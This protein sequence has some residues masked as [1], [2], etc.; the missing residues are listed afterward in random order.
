MLGYK[1]YFISRA[2]D[3][4]NSLIKKLHGKGKTNDWT[5]KVTSFPHCV[6]FS[7]P[8]LSTCMQSSRLLSMSKRQASPLSCNVEA[9][10]ACDCPNLF[11]N[12][13]WGTRIA[14]SLP[15][16]YEVWEL[17]SINALEN[18]ITKE[19]GKRE[20]SNRNNSPVTSKACT[21]LDASLHFTFF[22]FSFFFLAF[23]HFLFDPQY[24]QHDIGQQLHVLLGG[25]VA[26]GAS[27]PYK[28]CLLKT[29]PVPTYI[30]PWIPSRPFM[31]I[32]TEKLRE[33]CSEYQLIYLLIKL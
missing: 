17:V 13:S 18:I 25:F 4:C 3:N 24:K 15:I 14:F 27:Y 21:F 16:S 5:G 10:N 22:C 31:L 1:F 19:K 32:C 7:Y 20:K 30:G 23:K 26:V 2:Q 29:Q 8:Q 6:L 33:T 9:K 12:F 28:A 11:S